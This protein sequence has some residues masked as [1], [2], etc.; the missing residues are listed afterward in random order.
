[1]YKNK[2]PGKLYIFEGCDGSGKSTQAYL[3]KK[4]LEAERYIVFFTEWNSSD[5]V[6]DTTRAAKKQN[7]LTPTTFSLLHAT[8]FTDRYETHI[9]PH[10]RAG[11]IVICDRY[12][13]TAYARDMARGCEYN[14]V[15]NLYNFVVQPTKAFYF[16]APLSVSLDRILKGRPELMYHEAGL[17][18]GW[19]DDPIESFKIYQGIMKDNYDKMSKTEDLYVMDATLGIN[20]Q[21]TQLREIIREDLKDY[22]SPYQKPEIKMDFRKYLNKGDM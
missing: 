9:L 4:W 14:W 8:D 16:Q 3:L 22:V 19:C 11:Y 12:I 2:Y 5:L 6:Q 17:D 7:L 10:L 21:Q 20:R 13:Y 1:M 18:M 15:R